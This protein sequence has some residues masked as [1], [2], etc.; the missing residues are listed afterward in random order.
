MVTLPRETNLT[1]VGASGMVGG[2]ALRYALEDPT[3]AK[4]TTIGRKQLGIAHPKLK[5]VIHRDFSDC[6]ALAEVLSG[7][8]AV[9]FC[10]GAYTGVVSDAELRTITSREHG[11]GASRSGVEN[12]HH[13]GS[14]GVKIAE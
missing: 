3:V 1:I 7:Q 2:Y 13:V 12:R 9:V 8:V 10:L 4:V 5:E 11:V 6:S 14:G